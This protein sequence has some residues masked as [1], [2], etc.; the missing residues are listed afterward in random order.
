MHEQDLGVPPGV[1]AVHQATPTPYASSAVKNGAD[2][3][4]KDGVLIL[5]CRP[6]HH[7]N[8]TLPNVDHA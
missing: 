8:L 4:V 3:L 1:A 6:A 2:R 5:S 7:G